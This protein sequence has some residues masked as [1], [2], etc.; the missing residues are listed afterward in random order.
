MNKDAKWKAM[1]TGHLLHLPAKSETA[2]HL[3]ADKYD[4]HLYDKPLDSF[5]SA[6]SPN[7]VQTTEHTAAFVHGG[8]FANIAHGCNSILATRFNSL[9]LSPY[10]TA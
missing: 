5:F 7:L 2:P 10:E 8:P 4:H 9:P 3:P 1:P 6:L